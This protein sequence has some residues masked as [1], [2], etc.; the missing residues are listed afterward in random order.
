MDEVVVMDRLAAESLTGRLAARLRGEI[1][2]GRWPVGTQLPTESRLVSTFG[3]SRTVVREAVVALKAAGLVTTH[4][5]RGAFVAAASAEG[6]RIAADEL[7]S[8]EDVLL[9]LELR[10]ALE[11]EAAALAARRRTTAQVAAIEAALQHFADAIAAGGDGID[12]DF[13]FHLEVADATGNPYFGRLL[14]SL[15]STLIPRQRVRAGLGDAGARSIYLATV[16][17][18]HRAIARAIAGGGE[19]NGRRAMARHL[20]GTRY[21][22]LLDRS[23][24]AQ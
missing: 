21:R 2:S 17:R 3:V 7:S 8:L 24:A 6:F 9:V 4:Q 23:K 15:G 18:E 11:V 1:E 12:A 22:V 19:A 14:R 10:T 20:A 16:L 5:G 13:Q